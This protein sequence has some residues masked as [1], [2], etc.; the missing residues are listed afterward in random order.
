MP[1][2]ATQTTFTNVTGE[3]LGERLA[4]TTDEARCYI[5]G[6]DFWSAGQVTFLDG[7]VF[8]PNANR[9]VNQGLKKTYEINETEKK[10]THIERVQEI[11]HGSF[12]PT[13]MSATSSMAREYSKFYSRLFEMKLFESLK[14]FKK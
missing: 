2:R 12:T 9:Y 14:I 11:E 13:V 4:I 1:I 7:R 6:R 8:N 5:S 3:E 10:R